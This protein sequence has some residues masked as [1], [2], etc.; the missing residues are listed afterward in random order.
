V[1]ERYARIP[2][3]DVDATARSCPL[4]KEDWR[5]KTMTDNS[6]LTYRPV[7]SESGPIPTEDGNDAG[8]SAR[9][10]ALELLERTGSVAVPIAVALYALLYIG[11]QEMYA[12]FNINPEQA[13][14]DQSV[15]FGRLMG[16]LVLLVLV[17]FPLIGLLVGA[18]WLIN[19][20]TRGAASRA[21]GAVRRQPWI[22]ALI[23]AL[24]CGATYWGLFPLLG[25]DP[26][27]GVMVFIA[28]GL[29][30]LA[31]LVP[32]RLLRRRPVGRAGS[33]IFVGA[34]TGI[35]LGL[36]L[37]AAMVQGADQVRT[38][39]QANELLDA[40]GFQDQWTIVKNAEDDKPLYDGRSMM[41]L[42]ESDGTYV[43]YDCDRMETFRRPVET[44][45]LGE[46]LLGPEREANL[47]CGSLAE[48]PAQ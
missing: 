30:V 38:T 10:G 18:G 3:F 37:I 13:G 40:V 46:I 47:T 23:A 4:E 19:V 5:K 31:F 36:L 16:T 43:F 44:T 29:G 41:L 42:G 12:V 6:A 34:L 26:G 39:G 9:G 1:D 48:E 17:L 21:V 22:A 14:L 35:G 15:L 20:I 7:M 11:V 33:A 45:N 24:W 8:G 27:V 32:F 2:I 25:D 28:V